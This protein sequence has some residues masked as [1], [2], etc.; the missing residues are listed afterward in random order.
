[1]SVERA[2]RPVVC[3]AAVFAIAVSVAQAQSKASCSFTIFTLPSNPQIF[4]H[5][6]N[7]YGTVVGQ[8]NFGS[9]AS[10]QFTAFVHYAGGG[11]TYWI[12][13]GAVQ[14]GFGDRNN[15]GTTV[16]WYL[17][18][19]NKVHPVQLTGSA[20]TPIPP[21]YRGRPDGIN[22][23]NSVI[24]SYLDDN[25]NW[26]AYKRYS[27]GK[28]IHLNFPGA[29][30]TIADGSNDSGTIVGTFFFSG[31]AAYGFIYH[32]GEWAKVQYPKAPESTELT[33]ISNKG[34]IAGQGEAHAFLYEDGTFKDVV[35][36]GYSGAIMGAISPSGLIAGMADN[37]HGFLGSCH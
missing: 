33:G 35:V 19:S 25:G 11:T 30:G 13:S 3:V 14:S 15:S 32:N 4:V 29:A 36:P 37:T 7:D 1:M 8:T 31:S 21:P 28:T 23:Y 16:G 22:K 2:F 27:D 6:V 17:D 9:G 24:G 20:V 10:P 5:G 26:H 12:P 18:S 34:V